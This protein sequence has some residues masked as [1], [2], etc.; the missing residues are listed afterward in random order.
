MKDKCSG[1]IITEFVDLRR[2]MYCIRVNSEDFAKKAKGVKA[3]VVKKSITFD[4]YI[5]CLRNSNIQSGTQYVIRSWLKNVETIKPTKMDLSPYDDKRFLFKDNTDTLAWG[6]YKIT[7]VDNDDAD[8][9]N[10]NGMEILDL[11]VKD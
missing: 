9:L 10:D 2:K 8:V 6:H 7:A 4:D 1:E 11:L 3:C 5:E